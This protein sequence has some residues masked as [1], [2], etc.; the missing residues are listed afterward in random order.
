MELVSSWILVRFVNH[1]AMKGTP[2]MSEFLTHATA[3]DMNWNSEFKG[4]Q[5]TGDWVGS[6][7]IKGVQLHSTSRQLHG[8]KLVTEFLS[9]SAAPSWIISHSRGSPLSTQDIRTVWSQPWLSPPNAQ[10]S[11]PI[12]KGLTHPK[13][14]WHQDPRT[15]SYST[16]QL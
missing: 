15:L 8:P 9:A 3:F 10:E 14:Q 1:W 2:L 12:N 6:V 4:E 5:G 16:F 11:P 7:L 13:C